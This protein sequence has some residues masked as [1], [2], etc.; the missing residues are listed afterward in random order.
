VRIW[1]DKWIPKPSTY[2]IQSSCTI[3]PKQAMVAE[4]IEE[5]SANWNKPLI[6]N[7]FSLEEGKIICNIPVSKYQQKDKLIWVATTTG[8]F[9]VKSA[10]HLKK[11]IQDRKKGECSNKAICQAIWKIIWNLKVPN[12]TKVFLWRVCHNILPTKENLKRRGIVNEDMC[13]VCYQER[14]TTFHAIWAC[15]AA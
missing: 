3:L 14:E 7:I 15:P 11:E 8:E 9:T 2:S 1:G 13:Q 6:R 4:L 12:S 5:N 10:Y